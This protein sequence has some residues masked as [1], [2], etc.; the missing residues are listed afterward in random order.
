LH[1]HAGGSSD[2][3]VRTFTPTNTPALGTLVG[4]EVSGTWRLK[5]VDSE[6]Q[7]VGKL[8]SWGVVIKPTTA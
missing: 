7:D 3:L 8:N 4:Q 1:D 5:V 2:N 6:A